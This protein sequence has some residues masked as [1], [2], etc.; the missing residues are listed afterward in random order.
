[1]QCLS[2]ITLDSAFKNYSWQAQ[3]TMLG[4]EPGLTKCKVNVLLFCI[5]VPAP[6]TVSQRILVISESVKFSYHSLLL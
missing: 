5:I 6:T 2:G 1:M 4:I 3:K